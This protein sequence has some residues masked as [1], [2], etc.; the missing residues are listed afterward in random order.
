[1]A[2]AGVVIVFAGTATAEAQV[3]LSTLDDVRREVAPGDVVTIVGSTGDPT[4]GRLLRFGDTDLDIR[5][6]TLATTGQRQVVTIL[7]TD[8]KALER[9][10]DSS[11][12][13]AL[14][15]AGVGGGIALGMFV[16]AAAVDYNEIDE[17][18]SSYLALGGIFSGVGAL[19]GWAIDR[20]HS[21][22]HIRFDAAATGAARIRVVPLLVRGA[23]IA[24]AVSY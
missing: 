12:N 23:G 14:I 22:P 13:G 16:Y 11:R 2:A 7:L 6:E 21:K 3:R 9:F 24:L 1:V 8:L 17:W 20:A 5:T 10:R 15:G 4:T 19:T 18:G